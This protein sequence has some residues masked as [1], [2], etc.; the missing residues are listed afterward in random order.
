VRHPREKERAIVRDASEL[1]IRL[2]EFGGALSQL[3]DQAFDTFVGVFC[4]RCHID[5]NPFEVSAA[6]GQSGVPS[7]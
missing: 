4:R 5:L 3:I 1:A 2:L 7:L 6:G